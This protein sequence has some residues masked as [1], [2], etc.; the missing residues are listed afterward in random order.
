MVLSLKRGKS[1]LRL[2]FDTT[3]LNYIIWLKMIKCAISYVVCFAGLVVIWNA[4]VSITKIVKVRGEREKGR[5]SLLAGRVYTTIY[6]RCLC[7]SRR[8]YFIAGKPF[9]RFSS[10]T[11]LHVI[12]SEVQC[13][14]ILHSYIHAYPTIPRVYLLCTE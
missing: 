3:D 4:C 9:H 13:I 8:I 6:C 12:A 2:H 11:I 7:E 5:Y 14:I 1:G 10:N